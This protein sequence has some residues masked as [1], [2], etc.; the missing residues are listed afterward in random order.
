MIIATSPSFSKNKVLQEEFFRIFPNGKLNTDGIRFNEDNLIDFIKD[1]E[2][3]IVG[4]E[5]I[6]KK[7]LDKLPKLKYI[8]K[9]GVGLNNID[10][11]ECK[12]RDI[13]IG[14]IGGVNR[15]SVAEMTLGYMIMLARNLYITS[16]LL[17]EGIWKKHG[18]FEVS[19]KTIGI[20]GVGYIGKEVIRLLKPFD[21]KILVNDIINQDDYYKEHN[22][23]E[24]SKEYIYKNAD[25]ITIH[26][27]LD[28]TTENLIT[29]KELQMMKKSTILINSA[30]GGIINEDDLKYALKNNIILAAAIDAYVVEP[31]NDRELL[32][33]P[34]LICT[35]HIG[36]NSKEAV[37]AMGRNAIKQLKL[38]IDKG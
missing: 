9:Y 37:L 14:W 13:K 5:P 34:N 24:T 15:L 25:I 10:L 17:K 35:P 18:G 30:R 29:I 23:I 12:K 21:C 4:L 32:E 19:G 33:L 27:P 38:L 36:G 3:V 22:L 16:N 8:S 28:K 31:P 26:T 2:G 20:I 6:T 7:V 11:D 1:A